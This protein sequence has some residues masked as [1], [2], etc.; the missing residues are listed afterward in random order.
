M[1]IRILGTPEPQRFKKICL[2][3]LEP[4]YHLQAGGC[5]QQTGQLSASWLYH[6]GTHYKFFLM[7]LFIFETEREHKQGRGRERGRHRIRSRLQALSCQH[8]ARRGARTHRPWDHDL[9]RSR[10]LNRLSHPGAPTGTHY[11]CS[12]KNVV[13]CWTPNRQPV[14]W[15]LLY[16]KHLPGWYFVR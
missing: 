10:T 9:S 15:Y 16:R 3:L 6:A 14:R 7:F 8:R 4:I 13:P 12:K 11:K 5:G 1:G 2:Q